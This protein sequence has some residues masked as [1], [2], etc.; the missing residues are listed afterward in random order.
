MNGPRYIYA[1]R[2]FLDNY[3]TPMAELAFGEGGRPNGETVT[4]RWDES[5]KLDGYVMNAYT[6]IW[7]ERTSEIA[8]G[9]SFR[10]YVNF[11]KEE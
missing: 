11:G 1:I 6:Y 10:D 8:Y 3:R 2:I 4:I 5:D 7:D 9:S